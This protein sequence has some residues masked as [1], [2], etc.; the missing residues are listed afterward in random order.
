M[1][2]LCMNYTSNN[3]FVVD[4]NHYKIYD[5]FSFIIFYTLDGVKKTLMQ[6]IKL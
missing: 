5:M 4:N 3:L 2:Q 1:A 6:N